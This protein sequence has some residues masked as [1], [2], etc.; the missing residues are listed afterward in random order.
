MS[1]Q[2]SVRHVIKRCDDSLLNLTLAFDTS[3]SSVHLPKKQSRLLR[4]HLTSNNNKRRINS[5]Q[6]RSECLKTVSLSPKHIDA[7]GYKA[8]F[9]S[10]Y[11]PING[12]PLM[13]LD[14]KSRKFIEFSVG[15]CVC[16]S[17][18]IKTHPRGRFWILF[19]DMKS[20]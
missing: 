19:Y 3:F 14:M 16:Q 1:S 17:T 7:F 8:I 11:G 13:N 4:I 18:T 2:Q 10:L 9:G 20:R 12:Y 6:R 15:R 5:P